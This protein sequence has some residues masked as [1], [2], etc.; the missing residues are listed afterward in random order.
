M[1]FG[2]TVIYH[3]DVWQK[4]NPW[5]H[6]ATVLVTASQ[7]ENWNRFIV[8]YRTPFE[9]EDTLLDLLNYFLTIG[10]IACVWVLLFLSMILFTHAIY[11]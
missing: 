5:Q 8:N 1:G 7:G 3:L 2:V 4:P 11:M 9:G 6:P 10:T